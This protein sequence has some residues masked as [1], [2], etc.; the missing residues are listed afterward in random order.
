MPIIESAKKAVRSSARK[1]AFNLARKN[2]FVSSTKQLKRLLKN[3]KVD[4]AQ[5]LFKDVQQSID[6]A[7]KTNLLKKNTASRKISRLSAMV[8]KA[9]L[10]VKK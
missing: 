1:Q 5:A 10:T 8:K 2:A 9:K 6:K 3:G 7:A 4:E